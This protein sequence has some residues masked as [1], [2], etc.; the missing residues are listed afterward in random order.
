[1]AAPRPSRINSRPKPGQRSGN[2]EKR[3]CRTHPSLMIRKSGPDST[4]SKVVSGILLSEDIVLL[5]IEDSALQC[6]GDGVRAVVRSKFR[7]DVF[8]MAFDGY[9]GQR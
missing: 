2:V 8:E 9:L 6:Y 7:Q 3:R 1:M 4:P 5:Q